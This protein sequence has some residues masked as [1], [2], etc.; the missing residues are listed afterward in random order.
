MASFQYTAT[1]NQGALKN[2]SIQAGDKA[3]AVNLLQ[4]QGLVVTSVREQK[5]IFGD[6]DFSF[7]SRVTEKDLVL[8]SRQFSI[9]INSG[10]PVTQALRILVE[11]TD[12]QKFR[13]I[14]RKVLLDVEAGARLSDA[15]KKFPKVFSTFFVSMV[16]S[17][18]ASGKLGE[19]LDR[20]ADQTERDYN[21][22][23]A[24]R[25]SLIYPAFVL[26]LLLVITVYVLGWVIPQL[27]DIFQEFGAELPLATR[28]L[29]TLSEFVL[30]FWWII[31][32]MAVA[33]YV[34]L[35]YYIRTEEGRYSWDY[36][37]MKLPIL[38]PLFNKIATTRF[39]RNLATLISGDIPILEALHIVSKVPLNKVFEVA[40]NEAAEE[41]KGGIPLSEA[42]EKKAGDNIPLMLTRMIAVGETTGKIDEVLQKVSD[43]YRQE[44]DRTIAILTSLLEPIVIVI[45]GIGVGVL[46][47]A[48]LL[49]IYNLATVI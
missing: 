30:G 46:I 36:A 22:T 44:I 31:I 40:I 17:G 3:A 45:I 5:D 2:G 34:G 16:K 20:V 1:N 25:S 32:A 13:D 10:L 14:V 37:K 41:V 28:I 43:F 21:L 48:V 7:L 27:N 23:Q 49:P 12:N 8:F 24:I 19:M 47:A 6:I 39:A 4:S 29:I 35:S 38:G 11:Q 15:L 18:E 42:L 9:M 33:L 26:V